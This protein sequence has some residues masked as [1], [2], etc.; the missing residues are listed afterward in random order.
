MIIEHYQTIQGISIIT[1][2]TTTNNEE[3]VKNGFTM[4]AP[5][6]QGY[7]SQS[8]SNLVKDNINRLCLLIEGDRGI[9]YKEHRLI[10]SKKSTPKERVK[11]GL[12][13]KASQW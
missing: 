7:Y 11:M 3:A 13:E 5:L 10:Y 9:F 1:H 12:S 6:H 2:W 4:V 8:L